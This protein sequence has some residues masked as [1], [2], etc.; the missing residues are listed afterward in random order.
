[1]DNK[2]INKQEETEGTRIDRA[3]QKFADLMILRLENSNTHN[4]VT[5]NTAIICGVRP[6]SCFVFPWSRASI[7]F[8]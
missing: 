3:I 1:M 5:E 8:A 2:E 4:S 7:I 6:A